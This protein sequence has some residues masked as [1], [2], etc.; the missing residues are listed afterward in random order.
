MTQETLFDR[1]PDGQAIDPSRDVVISRLFDASRELIW[2]LW[3]DPAHI[4]K[5]WG[6]R[7]FSLE[8][9]VMDVR[10]GGVWKS[11]MRGPDGQLYANDCVFLDVVE[12][13]RIVYRL[14]GGRVEDDPMPAEVTWF[15]E[16][17]GQRTRLILKM[18]FPSAE[19]RARAGD[20]YKVAEGGEE[21]IDRLADCVLA[22]SK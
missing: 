21:T 19:A 14:S 22:M 12:P 16:P 13:E 10:P 1:L 5:W 18:S 9:D 20:L 11:T 2:A 7:G 8:I 15:F 17:Q 6:P 3:T 4:A